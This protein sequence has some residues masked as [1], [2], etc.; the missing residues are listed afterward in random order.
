GPPF[1]ANVT[2]DGREAFFQL[3]RDQNQ[4]KAQLKTAVE[5]WA[6]TYGV[7]EEVAE[8]E[9]AM[10]A[11]QTERRANLTTAIGQL[12]EAVNKLTSLEDA[13]DLTMVQTREQIEA[14]IDAMSPELRNLV[15]AAGRPPMP[16]RG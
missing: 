4:T 14:A 12:Q 6:S 9:T 7:S 1:L 11:E 3:F 2:K 16:P 15:I 5:S 13:Q 8:F 10:K